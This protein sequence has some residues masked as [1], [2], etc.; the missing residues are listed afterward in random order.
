MLAQLTL[1]GWGLGEML[2]AVI[3][4]AAV[5]GITYVAVKAMG[6][7]VP[8][9]T[10]QIVGILIVAVVAVFAIRVVLSL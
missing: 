9:W 3:V 8:A 6:L 10:W 4:I 5:L 7:P 2:V 1:R